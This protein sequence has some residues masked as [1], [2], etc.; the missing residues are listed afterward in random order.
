MGV[1]SLVRFIDNGEL[2]AAVYQQSNGQLS[3]VGEDLCTFLEGSKLVH[4][5]PVDAVEE[6]LFAGIG[7]MAAQFIAKYKSGPGGLR[8]RSAQCADEDYNYLVIGGLEA[9]APKPLVIEFDGDGKV[10]SGSLAEF[11]AFI[12]RET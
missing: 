6:S 1:R 5:V 10:F 3:G 9:F 4:G 11:R 12:N 2:V 8:L 7:C